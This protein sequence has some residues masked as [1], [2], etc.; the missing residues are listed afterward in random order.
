MHSICAAQM[1]SF[2]VSANPAAAAIMPGRVQLLNSQVHSAVERAHWV[3]SANTRL[4]HS[5]LCATGELHHTDSLQQQE[6]H[7]RE[8]AVLMQAVSRRDRYAETC[9]ADV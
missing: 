4:K 9:S 6:P 1:H 7:S 5:C 8:F 3:Q 2:M